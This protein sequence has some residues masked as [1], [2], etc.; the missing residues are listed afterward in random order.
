MAEPKKGGDA[1]EFIREYTPIAESI[2]KELNV[3]PRILLAKFG[4][5]TGWGKSVVPG[6]YNLGNIK[7]FSGSGVSAVDNKLKTRDNYM[8]FEDPDVFA[9]YY[10]DMMKRRFPDVVGTGSDVNAFNQALRPGQKGGYAEDKEYGSKLN[11][12]FSLVSNRMESAAPKQP[13]DEFGFGTGKTEA[14]KIAE[15]PDRKVVVEGERE[16]ISSGDAAL[17]GAGV[18]LASGVIAR[19]TKQP[20]PPRLE[21]AQERL[22]V[23]QDKL[24]EVQSRAGSGVSLD[25]LEKEFRIS[26]TNA[27][28]AAQELKAAEAELKSLNKA[29]PAS[30]TPSVDDAAAASRKLAGSSGNA[31]WARKMS[32]EIPDAVAESATSMRKADEKGAQKLIDKDVAARQKLQGM[33]LGGYELSGRGPQQFSLPTDVAAERSAGFERE[34][35]Q[36]QAQEAAERAR[37]ASEAEARRIAT[38][39]RVEALRRQREQSG[40]ARR[41]ADQAVKQAR[42]A[43]TQTQRAQSGVNVAQ[44][45]LD[46]AS[47]AK[48]GAL[49]QLGGATAKVAPKVLGVI[50]GAATGMAAMEAIDK[51]KQ[52]DYSGAVLPTLEAT[53]G[54]MSMLPPSHPILLALRGLGTAGG[55]A[56]LGYEGYKAVRGEPKTAE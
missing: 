8:K 4:M 10:A 43:Q 36:R 26:Q 27:N 49:S 40:L 15:E 42:T 21:A 1:N 2:G 38:Q 55:A 45:A 13:D 54:V 14:Q 56:L 41:D 6:T 48:P 32:D 31:N 50:S 28:L 53:F 17:A 34:L 12:A 52:G 19:N 7:D 9:S 46:R 5:E 20:V 35:A 33:G 16:G 51:F 39:S 11:S 47:E 3:D 37:L 23:A 24:A 44:Q 25:D 29:P 30:V 22:R 18:G